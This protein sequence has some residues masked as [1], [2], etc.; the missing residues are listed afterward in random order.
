MKYTGGT[1]EG[2]TAYLVPGGYSDGRILSRDFEC[3]DSSGHENIQ[4]DRFL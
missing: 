3:T 4:M 1:S 2:E